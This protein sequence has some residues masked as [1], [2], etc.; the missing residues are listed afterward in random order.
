M[1][2]SG[3]DNYQTVVTGFREITPHVSLLTFKRNWSFLAGQNVGIAINIG[4]NPRM[5]SLSGG[6]EAEDGEFIFDIRPEG[7]LTPR[8]NELRPGDKLLVSEPFGEFTGSKKPAWWIATGTGIAPFASMLRSGF[9]Q[10]KKLV[11]GGRYSDSFYFEK[12]FKASLGDNYIRCCSKET[13]EGLF[14]GRVTDWLTQQ[15]NIPIDI[16]Y[17]LCGKADM[18]VEVRDF[19]ISKHVPFE[20]IQSEIFF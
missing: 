8:L 9:G 11:H 14:S 18:I 10:H 19:L 6:M 4:D 20:K 13:G 1:S 3:S 16:T 17:Y 12:E 2:K 7:T 15:K 5:Y